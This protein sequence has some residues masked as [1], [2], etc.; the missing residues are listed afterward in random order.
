MQLNY[1]AVNHNVNVISGSKHVIYRQLCTI[2]E[3]IAKLVMKLLTQMKISTTN[4]WYHIAYWIIVILTLSLVFG[5]SWGN[6]IAAV[7]FVTM[8][9]PVVLGTSYFFNYYLV[10]RYF[11]KR[12]YL[13]F[14]LYTFYTIVISLY[15]E[16]LVLLFS[17]VYFANFSIHNMGPNSHATLLLGVVMYLL[18]FVGSFLLMAQQVRENQK[19]IRSLLLEKEKNDKS[20]LE[21]ISNRKLVRIPFDDIVYIESLAD[22]ITVHTD[23]DQIISKE[24][25]SKLNNDLPDM[26]LR[27][28]RSFIVNKNKVTSK[29]SGELE[30]GGVILTIGRSYQNAVKEVYRKRS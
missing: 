29:R 28:H 11:L 21:I 3:I 13:S 24:K 1:G 8:L 25:I 16:T 5:R 6:N 2:C 15:L 19:Q 22:Y 18:V 12:K 20:F 17:F 14:A 23:N 27:I 10:P 30:L 26:F 4:P 9:L 7:F